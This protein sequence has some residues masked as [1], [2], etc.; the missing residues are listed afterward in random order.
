MRKVMV[1]VWVV[2]LALMLIAASCGPDPVD[3]GWSDNG[4]RATEV[5]GEEQWYAQL[6][7]IAGDK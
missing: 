5:Y 7:A 4:E 3:G 1:Y 2:L 6:T